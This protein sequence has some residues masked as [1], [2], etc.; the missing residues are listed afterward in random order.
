MLDSNPG[1]SNG[2][3]TEHSK[4]ENM[5]KPHLK[6]TAEQIRI[7]E[8]THIRSDLEDLEKHQEIVAKIMEAT[9][10]SE[11]DVRYAL[12]QCDNDIYRAALFLLENFPENAFQEIS[13]KKSKN[14][15]FSSDNNNQDGE[16]TKST[17]VTRGGRSVGQSGADSE[18]SRNRGGM[19]GDHIGNAVDRKG[20]DDCRRSDRGGR[21]SSGHGGSNR[22]LGRGTG[23]YDQERG[24]SRQQDNLEHLDSWDNNQADDIWVDY[25]NDEY[26]G[27]LADS[28][29]FTSSTATES[30][31]TTNLLA[32]LGMEEQIPSA[33][34]LVGVQQFTGRRVGFLRTTTAAGIVA[35]E[36]AVINNNVSS[37]QYPESGSV[38]G[39]VR[40]QASDIV[41]QINSPTLSSD[42]Y[43]N[44]LSSHNSTTT[45]NVNS[46]QRN[47]VKIPRSQLREIMPMT[48]IEVPLITKKRL[49]SSPLPSKP[50]VA[51]ETAVN[52]NNVSSVQYPE[53]GRAAGQV[54]LQASDI[55]LQI[56]SP[57]LSSDQYSNSLSSHN[58]TTT[59]NVNS[60]QRNVV[61]IPR[62]Q[63]RKIMP[64]T[65][66]EVPLTTKKRLASSPLPSKPP[67]KKLHVNPTPVYTQQATDAEENLNTDGK[68]FGNNPKKS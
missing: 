66:I 43:S 23:S 63:L 61:K 62:S 20:G 6:P 42:Q 19:S 3:K 60:Y 40:L 27:S 1:F 56:N 41:L 15:T 34:N 7:A 59:A 11:Q 39:Q 10:R 8:L 13:K 2:V 47:V 24:F 67:T 17:N 65:P 31:G 38:A 37:V 9:E 26:T 57:T 48:P 46:Y 16:C 32:S 49:A 51:G 55:V 30:S 33:D 29:T 53:S 4:A 52:N 50:P 68:S 36:A 14:R 22:I 44:S 5:Q 21:G 12:Y 64:M 58:S 35:G 45:A 18:R 25:D 28:I 54:R